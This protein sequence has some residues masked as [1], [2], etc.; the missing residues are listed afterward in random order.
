MGREKFCVAE[1]YVC[2]MKNTEDVAVVICDEIMK[3][4]ESQCR[5]IGILSFG[6]LGVMTRG[7]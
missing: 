4:V 3:G 1:E 2:T 7:F 5:G 6:C